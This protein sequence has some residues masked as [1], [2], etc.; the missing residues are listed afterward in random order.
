MT[1]S[2]H[3]LRLGG[4]G[5]HVTGHHPLQILQIEKG[6]NIRERVQIHE[7][8]TLA[9]NTGASDDQIT[10]APSADLDIIVAGGAPADGDTLTFNGRG[11]Q[12]V[13]DA[14]AASVTED[15]LAP[16]TYMG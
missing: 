15:S 7:T 5:L 3:R 2:D 8:D 13:F 16:V 14:T 6:C 10:V 4:G 1:S 11:A 12:L 9:I